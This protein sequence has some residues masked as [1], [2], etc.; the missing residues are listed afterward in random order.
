MQL[1]WGHVFE[2]S[3]FSLSH[4]PFK[5][6]FE[7]KILILAGTLKCSGHFTEIIDNLLHKHSHVCVPC[8]CVSWQFKIIP[9][10][11]QS[12]LPSLTTCQAAA[13]LRKILIFGLTHDWGSAPKLTNWQT[14]THTHSHS[15]RTYTQVEQWVVRVCTCCGRWTCK[16]LCKR[17]YQAALPKIT[18]K[19]NGTNWCWHKSKC[20]T[21]NPIK[22]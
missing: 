19:F 6:F 18:L 21:H 7:S 4:Q 13:Y 1:F 22:K 5:L 12:H 16:R 8:V 10:P 9:W 15:S 17:N 3:W 14:N 11:T 20:L 2:L